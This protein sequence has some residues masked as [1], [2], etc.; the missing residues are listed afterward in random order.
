MNYKINDFVVC[1]SLFSFARMEN[2]RNIIFGLMYFLWLGK[3]LIH[4]LLV[5]SYLTDIHCASN[6]NLK[7][8]AIVE[9]KQQQYM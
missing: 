3:F 7:E 1:L 6:D 8:P 9:I 4:L 2:K 5:V